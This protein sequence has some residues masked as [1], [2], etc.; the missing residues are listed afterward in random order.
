MMAKETSY[1]KH[2]FDAA[3]A[4][5]GELSKRPE[6]N[7]GE[8]DRVQVDMRRYLS[9]IGKKTDGDDSQISSTFN[10]GQGVE[11]SLQGI[12]GNL[13]SLNIGGEQSG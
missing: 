2:M 1:E 8:F 13:K 5:M 3:M 7:L 11:G 9:E 4:Y 6:I 10:A 12:A